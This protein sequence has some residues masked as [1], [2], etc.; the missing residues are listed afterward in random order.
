MFFKNRI[1]FRLHSQ[2]ITELFPE[3]SIAIKNIAAIFMLCLLGLGARSQMI[4]NLRV[5][6][7]PVNSDTTEIDSLSL[8]MGSV[9]LFKM[10]GD[11]LTDSSLIIDHPRAVL[12]SRGFK[13]DIRIEYRVFPLNFSTPYSHKTTGKYVSEPGA[14]TSRMYYIAGNEDLDDDEGRLQTNGSISRGITV[15]NGQDVIMNSDLNLQVNG[16]ISDNLKLEGSISD[17]NIPIQPEGNS[18]Q[19]QD[20]D[21]VYLKAY[22]DRNEVTFGDYEV[23]ERDGSLLR[24]QKKAQGAEASTTNTVGHTE[25]RNQ[26]ALAVSKGKYCRK[27]FQGVEGNQGPY[28]LTGNDNEMYI[29]VLSGTEKVFVDG[30]LKKRGE[31]NDYSIDYNT[32]EVSFTP[33]LPITKNSRIAVEFEYSDK[34]YARYLVVSNNEVVN[35]RSK[36]WVN[37]YSEQDNRNQP[38]QQ[39]L[40]DAQKQALAD[41]GDLSAY[42]ES[43]KIDTT[44]DN[45]NIHY[46]KIDTTVNGTTYSPVYRYTSLETNVYVVTFSYVGS[47]KGHYSIAQGNING[48]V[49]QWEAPDALG[50]TKGDYEPV[51]ILVAPKKKQVVAAGNEFQLTRTTKTLVETAIS[52]N[53]QNTFSNKNDGNN[54]GF[55]FRA[56]IEQQVPLGSKKNYLV[57]RVKQHVFDKQFDPVDRYKS[58]EFERDWNIQTTTLTSNEY[59]T[60][61]GISKYGKEGEVGY[62]YELLNREAVYN[63]NKHGVYTDLKYRS[64]RL[65]TT[66]SAMHSRDTAYNT[67]FARYK[68][69]LSKDLGMNTIGAGT[70]QELNKWNGLNGTFSLL[71]SRYLSEKIFASRNDSSVWNYSLKAEARDDFAPDTAKRV[72]KQDSRSYDFTS[73]LGLLKNP[74]N[75]FNIFGYYR[76]LK[77]ISSTST[78][79]PEKNITGRI[80]H[81]LGLLKRLFTASTFYELGSGL[82]TKKTYSYV[83]V[84]EGQGVYMWNDQTDYNHNGQAEL[85]EFEIAKYKYQANYIKVFIPTNEYLSTFSNQFSEIIALEPKKKLKASNGFTKLISRFSTLSTFKSSFK[86]TD[87]DYL[88]NANPFKNTSNDTS[89]VSITKL[90]KNTLFFNRSSSKFSTSATVAM[91]QNKMLT[92]NGWELRRNE[93]QESNTRVDLSSFLTLNTRMETGTKLAQTQATFLDNKNYHINYYTV[94]PKLTLQPSP[95]AAFD[96]LFNFSQQR[97]SAGETAIQ[98]TIGHETRV[99]GQKFGKLSANVKYINISYNADANTSLAYLMLD[100]LQPGNNFTWEASYQRELGKNLR[101]SLLYQGQKA[102]GVKA[103]HTGTMQLSA[104]F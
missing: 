54:T 70:E 64:F 78:Q 84:T 58:S 1:L 48:K 96:L 27:T 101:L 42:V 20:F 7:I 60:E 69:S 51:V 100:A 75:K 99:S 86:T 85:D 89:M 43:G 19:I 28:K 103:M 5:K 102:Q 62:T 9:K 73:Q 104:F 72:F 45:Q 8:V 65:Q 49:Y 82:E 29:V 22:N 79:K 2:F 91:D 37:L 34:N 57:A 66:A 18:Q 52:S 24:Y 97:N 59:L 38:I 88:E 47:L 81:Q 46:E 87:K 83:E 90:V 32:A 13:G 14:D 67:S 77:P 15:G 76:I 21:K 94:E 17:S 53:D 56:G 33:F 68:I 55:G 6:T 23:K 92:T 39:D 12:I 26:G 63:G 61:A 74:N 98:K 50:N 4:S 36:T 31:D 35:R 30:Q 16:N 40:S 10:D 44:V 25:V 95:Y 80:E 11:Q 93:S 41:A 71:S 3:T